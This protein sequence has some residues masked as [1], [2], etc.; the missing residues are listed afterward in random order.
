MGP[1]RSYDYGLRGAR[2][3]MPG[4]FR[5]DPRVRGYGYGDRDRDSPRPH[6]VTARYNLD[7]VY[8]DEGERHPRNY[9]F[10][11]GDRMDR[12]GD[13]RWYRRPYTTT[14]GSWTMRGSVYPT[15]Y[16]YPDYGPA[17]GGRYPDEL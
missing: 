15:G 4:R 3:T 8:G 2:D 1:Y 14:G 13:E 10:Y 11:T 16:D 17:Y 5:G 9:S 12:M 7:Y 6:R